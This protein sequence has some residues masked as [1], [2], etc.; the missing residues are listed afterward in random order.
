VP[1]AGTLTLYYDEKCGK[2]IPYGPGSFFATSPEDVHLARNEGTEP[3]IFF[4]TYFVPRTT[5]LLPIRID[6]PSP[7]PGCPQ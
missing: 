1:G 2:P 4:A 7:G 6:A 5:P 3:V